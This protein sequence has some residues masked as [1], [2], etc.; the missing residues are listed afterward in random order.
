[1]A[2]VRIEIP[3]WVA[4]MLNAQHTDSLILEKE[5]GE[6][7]TLSDLLAD[8]TSSY[9]DFDKVVFNPDTGKVTDQVLVVLNNSLLQYT[10]VTEVKLRDGD[11]IMLLPVFSGG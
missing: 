5:V 8:L 7:T 6:E 11:S 9:A 1:M 3:P 2:K 10:D 4:S